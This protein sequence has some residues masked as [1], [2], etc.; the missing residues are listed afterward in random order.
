MLSFGGPDFPPTFS[1]EKCHT[2]T[3]FPI[4]YKSPRGVVYKFDN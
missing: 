3:M 4:N 2:G 1:C